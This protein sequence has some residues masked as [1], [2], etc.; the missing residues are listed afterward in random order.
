MNICHIERTL[1]EKR[2]KYFSAKTKRISAKV[3]V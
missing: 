3:L 2:E 1:G